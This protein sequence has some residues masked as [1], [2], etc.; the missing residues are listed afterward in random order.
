MNRPDSFRDEE[1]EP[2]PASTYEFDYGAGAVNGGYAQRTDTDDAPFD[3]IRD[4]DY[5]TWKAAFEKWRAD[6][7]G[8][9]LQ[10]PEDQA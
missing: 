1:G 7:A 8:D 3:P 5:A 10:Q 2:R 6:R 4:R 9:N